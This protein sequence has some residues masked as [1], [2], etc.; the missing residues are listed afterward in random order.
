MEKDELFPSLTIAPTTHHIYITPLF[1]WFC[2]SIYQSMLCFFIC[3]LCYYLVSANELQKINRIKV[4]IQIPN[5]TNKNI[6]CNVK[7]E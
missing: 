7:F 1:I 3:C 2:D 6:F 4:V 5:P